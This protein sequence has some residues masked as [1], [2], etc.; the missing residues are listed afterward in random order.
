MNENRSVSKPIFKRLYSGAN[1]A[2]GGLDLPK[3]FSP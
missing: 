1:P 2:T 3:S